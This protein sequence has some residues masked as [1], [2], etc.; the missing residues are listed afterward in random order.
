[1]A[2]NKSGTIVNI[3]SIVGEM[4]VKPTTQCQVILTPF[5][6]ISASP[7]NGVYAASKAALHSLTDTL[8]MEL[9]PFNIDVLLVAP[10]GTKS[11]LS[12]NQASTFNL[13]SDSLY[14]SY[15]DS[16]IGRM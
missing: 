14:V 3:G 12:Q 6:N 16:I 2:K 8:S 15:L 10:G 4:Y 13:P 7:W 5:F 9:R 1:M 11:N